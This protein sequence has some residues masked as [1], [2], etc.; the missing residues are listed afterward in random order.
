M[1]SRTVGVYLGKR[2]GE[3]SS[4]FGGIKG[5]RGH[6]G[7]RGSRRTRVTGVP[8]SACVFPREQSN[9]LG[10]W[11]IRGVLGGGTHTTEQVQGRQQYR[12]GNIQNRKRLREGRSDLPGVGSSQNRWTKAGQDPGQ[13]RSRSQVRQ[14][15]VTGI[16]LQN[17]QRAGT[18]LLHRR[19]DTECLETWV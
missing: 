18:V 9:G 19:T 16:S 6:L 11:R 1:Q 14:G 3:K 10:C 8:I 12:S 4:G 7:Y 13:E 15:S 2:G 17:S 5:S